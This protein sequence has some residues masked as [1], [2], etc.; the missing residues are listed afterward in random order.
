MVVG[1]AVEPLFSTSQ[2]Y[3]INLTCLRENFKISIHSTQAN[4]SKPLPHH[5]INF[6]SS[7]VCSNFN[8]FL[9]YYPTLLGI[10][11]LSFCSQ[12]KLQ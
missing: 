6:I 12:F 9:Q 10:S 7:R 8:E 11:Q 4:A 1:P 5:V 3:R 2:F